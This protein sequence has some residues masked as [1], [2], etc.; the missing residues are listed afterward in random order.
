ME[1]FGK[2]YHEFIRVFDSRTR[3][4]VDLKSQSGFF[5][6]STATY[7]AHMI[8]HGCVGVVSGYQLPSSSCAMANDWVMPEP[9][10]A[11]TM[12]TFGV[13][14]STSPAPPVP[15]SF[16]V[17]PRRPTPL[18]PREILYRCESRRLSISAAVL[19]FSTVFT[20]FTPQFF[21]FFLYFRVG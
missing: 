8:I 15:P 3:I 14:A 4:S 5:I 21:L 11:F 7:L 20:Q 18:C 19:S 6:S 16:P 9:P 12:R 10:R 17:P 2:L 13:G 1:F